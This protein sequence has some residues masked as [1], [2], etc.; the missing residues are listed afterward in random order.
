MKFTAPQKMIIEADSRVRRLERA[1]A[2]GDEEARQALIHAAAKGT[3]EGEYAKLSPHQE[4][5]GESIQGNLKSFNDLGSSSDAIW[6]WLPSP[7][8]LAEQDGYNPGYS[9]LQWLHA[10]KEIPG[11]PNDMSYVSPREALYYIENYPHACSIYFDLTGV[12]DDTPLVSFS[13]YRGIYTSSGLGSDWTEAFEDAAETRM[14]RHVRE[15]YQWWVMF[16]RRLVS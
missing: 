1:A 16:F 4:R 2:T 8:A 12:N 5:S 9:V 13:F 14:G 15:D 10:G 11:F 3:Y 6:S 7:A